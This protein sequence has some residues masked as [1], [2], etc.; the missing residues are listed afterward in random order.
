MY[1]LGIAVDLRWVASH[2]GV[3]GSERVN[4]LVKRFRRA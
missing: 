1:D 4:E 2:S 3:E